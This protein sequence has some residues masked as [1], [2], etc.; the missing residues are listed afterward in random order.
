MKAA[1]AKATD[2]RCAES[3]DAGLSQRPVRVQRSQ[4]QATLTYHFSKKTRLGSARRV[5]QETQP[6]Y[7]KL[8]NQVSTSLRVWSLA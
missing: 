5:R 6:V 7:F 3:V 4:W 1:D 2:M 8:A